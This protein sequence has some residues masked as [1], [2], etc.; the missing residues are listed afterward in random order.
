MTAPATPLPGDYGVSHGSGIIGELIRH[1]TES[2]AGHAF[3]YIGHGLIAEGIPPA[4]RITS[5][6][7]HPDAIWNTGELAP[8]DAKRQLITARAQA[9][10]GTPYDYPAY[11]AFALELLHIRNGK[12]LDPLFRR[13][14][15]RVCSADVADAYHY[16]GLDL[17]AGLPYPNLVS[18]ADLYDRIARL[19][20]SR[21][22]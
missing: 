11:I 12:Q 19:K 22:D 20:G 3:I 13:D 6:H 7:A 9:L 14:R 18:P 4:T 17:T 1:A 21:N 16:A 8:N 10:T 2:W 5:V 15:W